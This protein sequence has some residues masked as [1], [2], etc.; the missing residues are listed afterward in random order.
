MQ[1]SIQEV[2]EL[3]DLEQV[4]INIFRGNSP[5][6]H[7]QRVFGGQV[8]G[9]ALSAAA[10]TVPVERHPHSLHA[11]VQAP[12]RRNVSALRRWRRSVA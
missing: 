5:K 12:S 2:L 1:G 9:Q 8:L 6:D 11:R 10:Q 4:E 3:L 7:W